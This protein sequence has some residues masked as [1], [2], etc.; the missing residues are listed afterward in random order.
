MQ[1]TSRVDCEG[2]VI[3]LTADRTI[4]SKALRAQII[5]SIILKNESCITVSIFFIETNKQIIC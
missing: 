2:F 3:P 1:A 5:N 4:F